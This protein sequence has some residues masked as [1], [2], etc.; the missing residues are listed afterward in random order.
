MSGVLLEDARKSLDKVQIHLR[1]HLNRSSQSVNDI[2]ELNKDSENKLS[3]INM[4]L[5]HIPDDSQTGPLDQAKTVAD[6]SN[7]KAQKALKIMNPIVNSLTD[8][9]KRAQDL[10]GE[11]DKT[12]KDISNIRK[13]VA[14]VQMVMPNIQNLVQSLEKRQDTTNL[15]VSGLG[16]KLGK[17]RSQVDTA[18]EIANSI[19]LGVEF[20]P[21]TTLELIP[22][23]NLQLLATN[24]RFSTYFRTEKPN[25]FVVYLGNEDQPAEDPSAKPK[26]KDFMALEIENGYPVLSVDLGYGPERVVSDKYVAD[27][28]WRQ[29][30][31]D[32]VGN[33]VQLTIR[34][35]MDNGQEKLHQVNHT[36]PGPYSVFNVDKDSR[37]FV[38]GYPPD[39]AIQNGVKYSSFEGEIEEL[40]IGDDNIGLWN[41]VEA[42]SNTNGAR[43]RNKLYSSEK[44][45]T[46]YRFNGNGYAMVDA[47]AFSFKARSRVQFKFKATRESGDGLMFYVGKN[48]HFM[49]VE[50]REGAVVYQFK[51]GQHLVNFRTPKKYNDDEWHDVE[52][53]RDGSRGKLVV[54]QEQLFSEESTGEEQL[55]VSEVMYF[56]GH[57]GHMNHSEVTNSGFDG[58]IDKV[59]IESTPVDL[60]RNLKAL[61]TRR[62][63]PTKF[64]SVVSF[65]PHKHGY[66]KRGNV[67]AD[68]HLQV[69]LRFR[70]KHEEGV[71]F[72]ATNNDQSSTLGLALFEGKLY[73]TSNGVTTVSKRLNDGE[74]HTVTASHDSRSIRLN[75][76]DVAHYEEPLAASY[77][78][79][80]H[81]EIFF[82]GLPSGYRVAKN[83][84]RTSAYFLGCISDANVNLDGVNFAEA[85][86]KQN[87]ILDNCP[88]NMFDMYDM[89]TVPNVYP[90]QEIDSRI[91][92]SNNDKEN[93]IDDDDDDNGKPFVEPP[94]PK[95]V[96]PRPKPKPSTT[97]TTAKPWPTRAQAEKKEGCQLGRD[98]FDWDLDLDMASGYRF[99]LK[100]DSRAEIHDYMQ[101]KRRA[102][103]F[104]LE[105]KT[106]SPD[107]LLFYAADPRH[108]D[109][110]GLYMEGGKLVFKFRGGPGVVNITSNFEYHNGEWHTVFFSR[111]QNKGKMVVDGDDEVEA[112]SP[113]QV[114]QIHLAGPFYI[115]GISVEALE[116]MHMNLN[117]VKGSYFKGCIRGVTIN[118]RATSEPKTVDVEPCSEQVESGTYFSGGYVKLRE[119]L[120]VGTDIRI[121]MEIKA[122]TQN[123]LLMSVHGRKALLILQLLN[124]TVSFVVDNGDGMFETV[125]V[126]EDKNLCDG[127]WHSI[128][129]IKT[130][131]VITLQVD[132]VQSQP[133]IGPAK[134]PS[135]DTSRALFMGGHQHIARI[136]GLKAREPYHGCIRNVK[137]DDKPEMVNNGMVTGDVLVGVCPTF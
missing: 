95:P 50:M 23:Q 89:W 108:T 106:T 72:Y 134:T 54:D 68:N 133:T 119:K 26:Q 111:A 16:D 101:N 132:N 100:K 125:F 10:P 103:D 25:G 74:W 75:V 98:K 120:R 17:L 37:L 90:E 53:V 97:T 51:L 18:R 87:A 60:T 135:A 88:Q 39:F 77:L 78:Q 32:R 117:T 102:F 15:M 65:F 52:A 58:C 6:K 118:N 67:S 109:F 5:E 55:K 110:V 82:G 124:G 62:G 66:V 33:N 21:N 44:P 49:S 136:R 47:K 130:K 128:V 40:K 112:E 71:L 79:I 12:N 4:A 107:G 38:G 41:F 45:S 24:S 137:I 84:M 57:P 114:R 61:G 29:A 13:Q 1:P 36:L 3:Q 46:G 115:G 59:H 131:F 64:S 123:G 127:E 48:K 14:D 92:V 2:V 27:G 7:Q 42:Q 9:I 80:Q 83:A 94:P 56:G 116:D 11:M 73:L 28:E 70:T 81:G 30:I 34:E 126:P 104:Y 8:D 99:G 63:C 96:T 86:D 113:S 93:Q 35:E 129:A 43:E 69:Y 91:D 31:V 105:F 20:H 76:D 19:N 22:P 121:S 122:R 85:R